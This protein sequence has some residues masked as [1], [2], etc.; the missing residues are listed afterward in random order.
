[1]PLDRT[2]LDG[3]FAPL[4]DPIDIPRGDMPGDRLVVG[5]D[6]LSVAKALLPMLLPRLDAVRAANPAGRAVLSVSGGSGTGKSGIAALLAYAFRR[7]DLGAYVLSG[8]N[9]PHR[10]PPVNDAERVRRFRER[11]Y[12]ALVAQPD[13]GPEMDRA[14]KALWAADADADPALRS[15]N[16]WLG[17]YQ[18]AG[19]GALRAYLGTPEEID[20]DELNGILAAFRAGA[21]TL[22]LKRFGRT[23]DAIW[24]D[25]VDVRDV[26]VLVVEWTHG[27]SRFL[28]GVDLPVVLYATPEETLADRRARARDGAVD[29][30]FVARVL[31]IEQESLVAQ[32]HRAA[33]IVLRSGEVVAYEDF[34]RRTGR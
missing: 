1:M 28:S 14:V 8:D 31:A 34:R 6:R 12:K 13:Y 15:A 29:S 18:E 4:S 27:N 22:R 25:K 21:P 32:A 20:F 24:Y 2:D 26:P 33:A 30:P 3:V 9:Y 7:L 10:I 5:A 17:A 16:P 19:E 23:E 11:G